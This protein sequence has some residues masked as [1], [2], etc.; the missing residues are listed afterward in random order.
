MTRLPIERDFIC[1]QFL[2]LG[3][4]FW[5]TWPLSA[6]SLFADDE[7]EYFALV[8]GVGKYPPTKFRSLPGA[9]PDANELAKTLID[10]GFRKENVTV[11]TNSRGASEDPLL[12]PNA[13]NIRR[14][15]D[16][17]LDHRQPTDVVVIAM[18]GHGLQLKGQPYVFCP[19]DADAEQKKNLISIDEL[20]THL[21]KCKAEFKLLLVD[22]CREE[23]LAPAARNN[24]PDDGLASVTRPSIPKPPGGVAAFFSCTQGQVA[25]ERT[26]DGPDGK[27]VS[28][29]LFF[30]AVIRGL[31]GDAA[32]QHGELTLP[33]LEKFVKRD[34]EAYSRV[35]LRA[36]QYPELLNQ[37]RGLPSL[38]PKSAKT[39]VVPLRFPKTEQERKEWNATNE[40]LMET[41]QLRLNAIDK[42]SLG[43]ELVLIQPGK[44]TMGS[45]PDDKDQG[46][47]GDQ[48]EVTLTSPFW[49]AKTE[50]TQGQWQA[51]MGT[52][53]WKGQRFV[54]EGPE[55]AA[56]Y[57]SWNDA[58]EFLKKLSSREGV[59]YRLP[60]EAEWE[61]SCR[62]GTSTRFSFGENE[63]DLDRYGWYGGLMNVGSAKSELYAHEVGKKLA[64]PLGL[65]DMHGNVYEWCEDVKIDKLPGGTN[66]KVST[67]GEHRVLRGGS[68]TLGPRFARSEHRTGRPPDSQDSYIGFRISRT[69]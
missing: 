46:K 24:L 68:W 8:V 58:Q 43:M 38:V 36:K 21:Q 7:R 3:F 10:R 57:V 44:F 22:A 27:P 41:F 9:E 26:D 37:T 53:P 54:K 28:H 48:V 42:N 45:P 2:V 4:L 66:P 6:N 49:L 52:T 51:V 60:T 11:L 35:T 56:T 14:E 65:Y 33:D 61:W 50:V 13:E 62:A 32:D 25:R 23:T 47:R 12:T 17:L 59:T 67:G 29:G 20:Y 69:Q 34:V 63:S 15:I 5:S 40:R 18:A 31:N 30:H 55:I 64:N 39:K 19:F 1:L 16:L